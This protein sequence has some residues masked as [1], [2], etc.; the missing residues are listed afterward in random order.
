MKE[1]YHARTTK[2]CGVQTAQTF[3]IV[4]EDDAS[5]LCYR[6][7][8]YYRAHG[9]YKIEV[10]FFTLLLNNLAG[11]QAHMYQTVRRHI[12]QLRDL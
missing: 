5:P 10:K 12:K 9:S 6:S 8:T 2:Q 4:S 11:H 7:S 3:L 1:E